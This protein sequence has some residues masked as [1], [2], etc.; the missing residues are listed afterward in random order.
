ML[1]IKRVNKVLFRNQSTYV[2]WE[3]LDPSDID[4]VLDEEKRDLLEKHDEMVK[5]NT[6]MKRDVEKKEGRNIKLKLQIA[7]TI[8]ARKTAETK[9]EALNEQGKDSENGSTSTEEWNQD[10]DVE[11]NDDVDPEMP[12]LLSSSG[13]EESNDDASTTGENLLDEEVIDYLRSV[14]TIEPERESLKNPFKMSCR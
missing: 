1:A 2:N 13:G 8:E 11:I 6:D 10:K 5:R 12:I 9:Y 3:T 14:T 4:K 7:E